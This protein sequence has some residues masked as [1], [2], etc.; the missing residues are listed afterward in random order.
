M[1]LGTKFKSL[2]GKV[3]GK[4]APETTPVEY[5]EEEGKINEGLFPEDDNYSCGGAST[6]AQKDGQEGGEKTMK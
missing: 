4:K 6:N 1:D 3:T 5:V 2:W